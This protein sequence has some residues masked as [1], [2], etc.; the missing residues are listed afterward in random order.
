M[1]HSARRV[2]VGPKPS[3]DVGVLVLG[4]LRA[5]N[6]RQDAPE[7]GPVGIATAPEVGVAGGGRAVAIEGEEEKLAALGHP[8]QHAADDGVV[9]PDQEV[10]AGEAVELERKLHDRVLCGAQQCVAEPEIGGRDGVLEDSVRADRQEPGSSVAATGQQPT[11][12]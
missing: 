2:R 8:G 7:S 9:R 10:V 11:L 1:Q 5:P 6:A 3:Q 12:P 4:G